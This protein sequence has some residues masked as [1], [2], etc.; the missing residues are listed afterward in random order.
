MGCYS[1]QNKNEHHINCFLDDATLL[2][3][4]SQLFMLLLGTRIFKIRG[5]PLYCKF[6][7]ISIPMSALILSS[8]NYTLNFS[9]FDSVALVG[10]FPSTL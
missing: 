2:Y 4:E 7:G 6:M 10:L 8:I 1:Y 5:L 3:G 9:P